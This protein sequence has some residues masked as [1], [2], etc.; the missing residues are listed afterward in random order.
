MAK[1]KEIGV[2]QSYKLLWKFMGTKE[3]ITFISIFLLSTISALTQAYASI[4][5]SIII[6]RFTNEKIWFLQIFDFTFLSVG[7]YLAVACGII[8][9]LW[10]F[11]MLNYRMIDIFG[12]KMMCIVNEK[13]Q[14]IILL[15]RKNLDFGMTTGEINYIVK[16][17]VDNIY[18]LIE[19]FC[20]NFA[21]NIMSVTLMTIQLFLL[22]WVVGLIELGLIAIILFF[23]YLRTKLQ[24]KVVQNIESTNAKIGNHFLMSLTNLPMII[25][26]KS[27]MRELEELNKLN[28]YFYKEH[29]KRANIGFWYWVI[30][31]SIEYIGLGIL[32]YAYT[33][34]TPGKIVVAS[35]TM[36]INQILT[37]YGLIEGWG[38]MVSNLQSSAIKFCNLKKIYPKDKQ[39]LTE[40]KEK[41][42]SQEKI[43]SIEV[44]NYTVEIGSFKACYNIKF[45]S[46]NVYV[47]NGTSGKGKTTLINAICGLREISSGHLVVNDKHKTKSLYTYRDKISYLFQDSILF[48]RSVEENISYPEKS[49]NEKAQNLIKYFKLEK[50]IK[51]EKQNGSI[52]QTLSGGEKKRLD[53]IRTVSKD[54][55][56]Y[57]FDEPTNDLDS[58]N[59]EKVINT[60]KQMVTEDKI[61][62]IVSHDNRCNQIATQI[63]N[64]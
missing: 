59:V 63:V 36:I 20:W 5:P 31:I 47:I 58:V 15:E 19:P 11:G 61:I 9:L 32:I 25:M 42:L 26:F 28:T 13:A 27:K 40:G 46:G 18:N 41:S 33:A 52:A 39:I 7:A 44:Q 21:T 1:N 45:E 14:D 51:R 23:V 55:D 2:F 48:D 60:I 16:N 37:I 10:V 30:V 56:I 29:K 4:L 49:L 17:A 34:L 50:I 38:Y 24:S 6:A 64:L 53:F 54:K 35:V 57:L 22:N 43:K 12:R 62:I 8:V 3:R